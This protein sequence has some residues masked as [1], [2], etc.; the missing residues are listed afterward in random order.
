MADTRSVPEQ[1]KPAASPV[2]PDV[3]SVGVGSALRMRRE[4]LGWTL[5][6]IADWLRI[7]EAYLEALESG[8]AG[9]FRQ[10]PTPWASCARTRKPWGL[11]L[12]MWCSATSG[13]GRFET[14]NPN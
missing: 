10:R 11:M 13:K 7:R 6:Q 4:Q 2:L 3:A 8:R 5:P 1:E 14:A 12:K 9:V